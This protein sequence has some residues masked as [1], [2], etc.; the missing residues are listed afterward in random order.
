[1]TD[2]KKDHINLAFKAKTGMEEIDRRFYYEPLMAKH[3]V[4]DLVPFK[5]LGKMLK[6]PVWVSS[7][8]GGTQLAGQINRN[9]ASLCQG[10][11]PGYGTR[12]LSHTA[13]KR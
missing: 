12:F 9:L 2:R 1:M 6:A 4:S 8:T 7:M 13:G 5:F 3:P 10:I 11:W